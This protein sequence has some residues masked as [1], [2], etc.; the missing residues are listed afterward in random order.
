MNKILH[1]QENHLILTSPEYPKN[2]PGQTQIEWKIQTDPGYRIKTYFFVCD[3]PTSLFCQRIYVNV[4]DTEMLSDGSQEEINSNRICGQCPETLV[5]WSNSIVIR[6]QSDSAGGFDELRRFALRIERT[7]DMPS[8]KHVRNAELSDPSAP[9]IPPL[10][11]ENIALDYGEGFNGFISSGNLDKNASNKLLWLKI[12]LPSVF[13]VLL[14]VI[15]IIFFVKRKREKE[16]YEADIGYKDPKMSKE[17][18]WLRS[19]PKQFKEQY[20]SSNPGTGTN[21]TTVDK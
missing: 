1:L 10:Y 5:S 2:V 11:Y 18:R 15:I 4:I 20:M 8:F 3:I 16:E 7:L 14:L 12:C 13:G 19:I 17:Q 6:L 9:T 21:Q